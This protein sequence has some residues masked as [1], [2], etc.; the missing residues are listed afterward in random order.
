MIVAPYT[1]A[2]IETL[3]ERSYPTA[4]IETR[5]S[6]VRAG[7]VAPYTGAWIETGS[8]AFAPLVAPYTGAWIETPHK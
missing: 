7:I 3:Q 6:V 4:C 2:W 1:G 5:C 8:H